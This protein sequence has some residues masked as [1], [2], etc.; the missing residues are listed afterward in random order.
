M[1]MMSEDVETGT[2]TYMSAYKD[3]EV[4]NETLPISE[5]AKPTEQCKY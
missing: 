1:W 4:S 2:E 5:D 3:A